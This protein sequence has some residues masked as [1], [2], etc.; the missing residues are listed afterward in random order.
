MSLGE[1]L[2]HPKGALM[3]KPKTEVIHHGR[4]DIRQGGADSARFGLINRIFNGESATARLKGCGSN[5]APLQ[6]MSFYKIFSA[7]SASRR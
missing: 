5:A 3:A 7:L 6:W 2:N 1:F 4:P